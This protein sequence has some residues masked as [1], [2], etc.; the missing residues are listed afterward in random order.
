PAGVLEWNVDKRYLGDLAAHGCPVVHTVFLAPGDDPARLG[1]ALPEGEVV[2][3]P[4]V[5]AGSKDT[6]RHPGAASGTAIA[7]ARSLLDAGRTVMVQPYLAAVD[8]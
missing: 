3:K 5:S 6:L 4:V 2:V 7:H 8:R 1:D